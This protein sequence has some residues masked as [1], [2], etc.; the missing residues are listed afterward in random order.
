[1]SIR[2]WGAYQGRQEVIDQAGSVKEAYRM[3]YEYRLAFGQ[4]WTL[5][6]GGKY[7][8]ESEGF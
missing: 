8:Q 3:L 7:K 5:W 6:L 1:M 4:S 2:I